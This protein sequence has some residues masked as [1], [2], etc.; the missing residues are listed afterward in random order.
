MIIV[1][2]YGVQLYQNEFHLF[3]FTFLMGLLEHLNAQH[4]LLAYSPALL[5]SAGPN[6]VQPR[7]LKL[8]LKGR[9]QIPVVSVLAP[10]LHN[11]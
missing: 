10:I 9:E 11:L 5:G 3:R 1:W 6:N 8:S 4:S 7:A 2:I